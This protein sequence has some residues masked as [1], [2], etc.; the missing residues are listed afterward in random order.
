MTLLIIF[1]ICVFITLA[2]GVLAGVSDI[3][4]MTIPNAY[5]VYVII[6]FFLAYGALYIGE[7]SAEP[8]GPILYH[9]LAALLMFI[10]TIILFALGII[11]A[12][13]SKF[14]TACAFWIGVKYVPVFLFFMTLCGGLLGV[15]ALILRRKKPFK[16]PAEGS[17]VAQVQG[18]ADKVPY[19]VAITVGML[20]AIVYAGYFSSDMLSAF[21]ELHNVEFDL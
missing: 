15:I 5:S 18:G 8:F 17:W 10:V 7:S 21:V 1:L 13:D 19:G 3:K 9:L 11:G 16:S 2:V 6:L 20:F 12:G 14:A 4:S